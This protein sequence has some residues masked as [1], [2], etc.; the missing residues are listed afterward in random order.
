M[1]LV[2]AE[3]F[4]ACCLVESMVGFMVSQFLQM[5]S[6]VCI[7]AWNSSLMVSVLSASNNVYSGLILNSRLFHWN[8]SLGSP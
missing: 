4:S 2:T 3:F 8:C 7:F 6:R 5:T 1:K